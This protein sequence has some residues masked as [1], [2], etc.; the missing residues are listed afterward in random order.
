MRTHSFGFAL[1]AAAV[2]CG[3]PMT[4]PPNKLPVP[5]APSKILT[6]DDGATYDQIAAEILAIPTD[7]AGV[8]QS[9]TGQAEPASK[10]DVVLQKYAFTA[11]RHEDGSY[12]GRF[13]VHT[14]QGGVEVT[15]QGDVECLAAEALKPGVGQA[16]IAGRVTHASPAAAGGDFA[17]GSPVFWTVLDRGESADNPDAASLVAA[18]GV[19]SSRA[20]PLLLSA[21]GNIQVRP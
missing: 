16:G 19:C 12:S 14:L 5:S 3:D 4:A 9:A 18:G 11:I 6:L 20:S 17:V 8:Q 1:V 15:A 10:S 13:V 7:G 21:N 2:A